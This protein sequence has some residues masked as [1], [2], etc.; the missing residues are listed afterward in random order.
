M[1]RKVPNGDVIVECG[2]AWSLHLRV[3]SRRRCERA[4][5]SYL[6]F[7]SASSFASGNS[8]GRALETRGWIR[9]NAAGPRDPSCFGALCPVPFARERDTVVGTTAGG[10]SAIWMVCI[11]EVFL[12]TAATSVQD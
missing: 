1:R 9:A 4:L 11:F 12:Q 8:C 3:E 6:C 2:G 7:S 10:E 5:L